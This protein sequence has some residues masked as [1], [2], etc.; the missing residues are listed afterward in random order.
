MP[1]TG[2]WAV[3]QYVRATETEDVDAAR[4]I[5]REI[6]QYNEEDLDATWAVYCWLRDEV[7]PRFGEAE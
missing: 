1:G 4:R 3:A 2:D 6:L 7:G 5:L